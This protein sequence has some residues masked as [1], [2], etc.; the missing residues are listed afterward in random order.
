MYKMYLLSCPREQRFYHIGSQHPP[1]HPVT[2][3]ALRPER[4][5]RQAFIYR[6]YQR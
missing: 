1:R 3:A 4:R 5:E 6:N 2:A